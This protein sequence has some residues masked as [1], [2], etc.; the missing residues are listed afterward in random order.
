MTTKPHP[1]IYKR[2][3]KHSISL[4]F[5]IS[6]VLFLLLFLKWSSPPYNCNNLFI[7]NTGCL[8]K[9]S[10]IIEIELYSYVLH[11][12]QSDQSISL[13]TGNSILI[14]VISRQSFRWICFPWF[15]LANRCFVR[16]NLPRFGPIS[17]GFK[18]N[19]LFSVT[20]IP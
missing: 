3:L 16:Y 8:E 12:N 10:V 14:Y 19:L 1:Q 18:L 15:S 6:W 13:R 5:S 17:V 4:Q 11:T 20:R 2:G 9:F 7:I